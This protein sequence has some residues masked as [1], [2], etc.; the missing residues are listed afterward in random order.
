[1]TASCPSPAAFIQIR[2]YG[3][4]QELSVALLFGRYNSPA[5][6]LAP[7]AHLGVYDITAPIGEGGIGQVYRATEMNLTAGRDQDSAAVAGS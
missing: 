3:V 5:L 4:K 6:A 1:L 2:R 7:G